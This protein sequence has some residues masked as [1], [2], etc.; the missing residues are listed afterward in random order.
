M[1]LAGGA[2][3]PAIRRID[4]AQIHE[5]VRNHHAAGPPDAREV[6]AARIAPSRL[7]HFGCHYAVPE[8]GRAARRIAVRCGRKER[9]GAESPARNGATCPAGAKPAGGGGSAA[10]ASRSL[11][12]GAGNYSQMKLTRQLL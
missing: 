3:R 7:E 11:G 12:E 10:A 1:P 9:Q 2:D 8:K 6:G 5:Q 4:L